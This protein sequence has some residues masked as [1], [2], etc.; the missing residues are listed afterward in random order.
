MLPLWARVDQEVMAMKGYSIFPK[1]PTLLELHDQIVECHIWDTRWGILQ[2]VYF[3][4][5]AG[6]ASGLVGEDS[7]LSKVLKQEPLHQRQFSVILW[8]PLFW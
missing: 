3:T 8:I 6:W 4:S 1:A 2:L 5:P 7:T